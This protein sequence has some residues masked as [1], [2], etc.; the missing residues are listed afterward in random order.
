MEVK[1]FEYFDK[2]VITSDTLI[3]HM[4]KLS[5]MNA[6]NVPEGAE[7]ESKQDLSGSSVF[8]YKVLEL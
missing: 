3:L 8:H 7:L 4:G 6:S 2:I 5:L 1:H